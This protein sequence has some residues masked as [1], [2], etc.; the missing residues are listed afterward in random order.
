MSSLLARYLSFI[1]NNPC[2]YSVSR[3]NEVQIIIVPNLFCGLLGVQNL[4]C[5]LIFVPNLF[6]GSILLIY[7]LSRSHDVHLYLNSPLQNKFCTPI[8]PLQNKFC[9]PIAPLQNKFCTPIA[10]LQNKFF[11]KIKFVLQS[12]NAIK[13][14]S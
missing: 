7:S 11:T 10:P 9:T 12:G 14:E 6:C 3:L 13:P 5:G 8:A 2:S 1:I 4:F